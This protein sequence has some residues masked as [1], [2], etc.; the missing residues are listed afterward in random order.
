MCVQIDTEN[1]LP[2]TAVKCAFDPHNRAHALT[3]LR[4][5]LHGLGWP[6]TILHLRTQLH[7]LRYLR[8][9]SPRVTHFLV[10][11]WNFS[12]LVYECPRVVLGWTSCRT[13]VGRVTLADGT[14]FHHINTSARLTETSLGVASVT[15]FLDT[16]IKGLK[17]KLIRIKERKINFAKLT[18]IEL[19]R[20]IKERASAHLII[21]RQ[22]L[23]II[24]QGKHWLSL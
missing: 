7:G 9:P 3:R 24:V 1:S 20:K 10:S 18:V 8:Y 15:K 19:L 2:S 4:P 16:K 17:Q 6:E 5:L 13:S 12:D 11:L 21:Q 14:T 23:W 22:G